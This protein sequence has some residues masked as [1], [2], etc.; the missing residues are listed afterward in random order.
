MWYCEETERAVLAA[1]FVRPVLFDNIGLNADDYYFEGHR[2]IHKAIAVLRKHGK[3]VD[4]LTVK[5]VLSKWKK[6]EIVGGVSY[7]STLDVYLPDL[8]AVNQYARIVKEYSVRRKFMSLCMKMYQAAND[9]DR[10]L[11]SVLL[12]STKAVSALYKELEG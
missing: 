9:G 2:L 6:L 3:K 8:S 12:S 11:S 1:M 5:A 10:K 7:I 4:Y